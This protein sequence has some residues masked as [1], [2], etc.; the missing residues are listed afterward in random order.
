[1]ELTLTEKI[2]A[3]YPRYKEPD[4]NLEWITLSDILPKIEKLKKIDSLSVFEIGHSIEGR[5]IFRIKAGRGKTKI[6]LWSQMHGD[7][8]T[9][10]K[11]IFDLLNF[12][13]ADDQFNEFRR[14]LLDKLEINFVP[15]LNPDGAARFTRENAVN[16]DLNRDAVSLQCPESNTLQKIKDEIKPYFSF[17]LHDQNRYYSVGKT[18]LTPAL[19]FLAPP[20]NYEGTINTARSRAMKMIANLTGVLSQII[21]GRIAKYSDDHEPRSFGDNFNGQNSAVILIESGFMI[22]DPLK[23]KIRELNF[24]SLITSF[25]SAA[26]NKYE[27]YDL[28]GYNSIP[29]NENRYFDLMLKNGEIERNGVKY[30]ID[31]GINRYP[32]PLPDRREFYFKGNI[33]AI[34]DLSTYSAHQIIDCS[35]LSIYGEKIY[36]VELDTIEEAFQFNPELLNK[37]GFTTLLCRECNIMDEFIKMPF[38]IRLRKDTLQS[39]IKTGNPANLY[40]HNGTGVVYRVINGFFTA[41]AADENL[42]LNGLIFH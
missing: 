28:E 7:E 29:V 26:S 2:L 16:I 35:G 23:E 27:E 19:S 22:D 20:F 15:M 31:I 18:D 32:V 39:E 1:M 42:I 25:H 11:A 3:E 10:T 4:L 13:T 36:P 5:E 33:E 17:N 40:L 34:G 8:P 38:N 41:S 6:L 24:Y 12:L 30:K 9:A 21:P 37:K 14:E